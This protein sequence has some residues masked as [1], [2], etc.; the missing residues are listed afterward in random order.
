[1]IPYFPIVLLIFHA[2]G[3]ALFLSDP[4]MAE[5]TPL[6][7][8]LCG[9]LVFLTEQHQ[10]TAIA[11]TLIFGI[12]FLIEWIGVATGFLFGSYHYGSVL[13]PTLV[14][15]PIII[16]VN[17]MV[18]VV[19]SVSLFSSLKIPVWLKVLL[20]GLAATAMDA[21]IEPVAIQYRFWYWENSA[22][23]L[24]NYVCWF[25]FASLF[26]AIYLRF[27]DKQ[28]RTAYFLYFIWIVFF[29]GLN[30]I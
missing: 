18:I 23:P 12:G 24:Y 7:L 20:S 28:N 3:L 10:R 16:G 2:V 15:I 1:M 27:A 13:G 5:L 26:A 14:G 11:Y 22:I 17:W 4:A 21:L 19:A 29:G 25:V 30:L 9:F 6:N 8:L